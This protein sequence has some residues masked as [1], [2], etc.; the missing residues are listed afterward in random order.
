MNKQTKEYADFTRKFNLATFPFKTIIEQNEDFKS[1]LFNEFVKTNL[2]ADPYLYTAQHLTDQ[3]I[4]TGLADGRVSYPT[5]VGLIPDSDMEKRLSKLGTEFHDEIRKGIKEKLA[6][7]SGNSVKMEELEKRFFSF[8]FNGIETIKK[9]VDIGIHIDDLRSEVFKNEVNGNYVKRAETVADS[10]NRLLTELGN[11]P[12]ATAVFDAIMADYTDVHIIVNRIAAGNDSPSYDSSSYK[13]N[14]RTLS[15]YFKSHLS[16]VF[17]TQPP[18]TITPPATDERK[19]VFNAMPL[20]EVRRWFIQLAET[21][22][23][24]GR[25]FLTAE[26]V[27]QFIDRAFCGKSFEEELFINV[28]NGDKANVVGLFHKF[29]THCINHKTGKGKIDRNAT[30]E[31]YIELLTNH[32]GNWKSDEVRHNFRAGGEWGIIPE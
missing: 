18:A 4:S 17:T 5:H 12:I 31:R 11:P 28:P 15:A 13:R 6:S 22:S 8:D 27:E 7:K 30:A 26:Q 25:P 21:N 20:D 32:F 9:L 1:V 2:C 24:N 29:Y 10:V 19:N 14:D 16:K 3:E 23:K